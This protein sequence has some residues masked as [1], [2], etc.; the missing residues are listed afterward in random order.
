MAIESFF[1]WLLR[2]LKYSSHCGVLSSTSLVSGTTRCSG[3]SCVFPVLV[4]P[5]P[6]IRYFSLEPW[7]FY[8]RMVLETRIWMCWILLGCCCFWPSQMTKEEYTYVHINP[9][10]Y[11]YIYKYFYLKTIFIYIKLSMGFILMSPT[12]TCYHMDHSS[13]L[14]S[15]VYILFPTVTNLAPTISHSLLN[16]SIPMYYR[17]LTKLLA[18]NLVENNFIN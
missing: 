14:P 9:G 7:F 8:W 3:S 18:Y 17:V 12:L 16:C 5:S 4:L 15:L 11:T 6:G 1:S 2:C 10:M 13:L